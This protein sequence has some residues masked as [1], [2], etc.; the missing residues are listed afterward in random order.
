MKTLRTACYI[1]AV[2][3]IAGMAYRF[4][5][6][7]KEASQACDRRRK[8]RDEEIE[9]VERKIDDLLSSDVWTPPKPPRL[10]N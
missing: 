8:T 1:G 10:P 2:A 4:V 9:Q 3:V 5:K 6:T 7:L